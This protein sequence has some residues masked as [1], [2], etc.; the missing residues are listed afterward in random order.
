[1]GIYLCKKIIEVNQG[2]ITVFNNNPNKGIAILFTIV[3][4]E[5]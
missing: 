5:P 1:M 2:Q 4:L 3:K